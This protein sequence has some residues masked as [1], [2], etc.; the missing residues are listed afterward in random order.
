LAAELLNNFEPDLASVKL[1]PSDGGRFEVSA[2][3]ELL[4]S[5]LRS[6]RHAEPG[7]IEKLLAR[8]IKKK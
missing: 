7:E 1:V 5:K 8:R 3:G 4:Y 2:D 6:G